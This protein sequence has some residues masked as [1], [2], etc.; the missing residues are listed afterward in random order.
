MAQTLLQFR[1]SNYVFKIN[2]GVKPERDLTNES[3]DPI[4]QDSEPLFGDIELEVVPI[5][6]MNESHVVGSIKI[7]KRANELGSKLGHRDALVVH[8]WLNSDEG[9]EASR[10]LRGIYLVFTGTVWVGQVTN[11]RSVSC[12]LWDGGRW[13]LGRR[14]LGRACGPLA[15]LL[16]P[17]PRNVP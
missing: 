6:K 12:L 7:I 16:V 17:R 15:R 5:I 3:L 10:E 1:P 11:D 2:F 8:K 4:E 14:Y 9:K 13:V